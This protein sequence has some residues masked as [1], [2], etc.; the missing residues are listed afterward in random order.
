MLD[1]G[2]TYITDVN[3]RVSKVEAQLS[4]TAMDRNPYQQACVGKCGQAGDEGGHLVAASLGGAGDRINLVPQSS[5]LNRSDWKAMENYLRK[6]LEAGKTV[7]IK[8]EVG[9]SAGGGVRPDSFIVNA[10]IDGKPWIKEF[11]Q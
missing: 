6:E 4:L 2:H 5:T 9:Y 7:S 11:S 3:G 1:N 10:M 8:I